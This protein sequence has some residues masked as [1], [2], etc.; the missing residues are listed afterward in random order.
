MGIT[1][2]IAKSFDEYIE[3]AVKLGK[4][5]AWRQQM[6]EMIAVNKHR[7]YHDR[8]CIT[9][10]ENFLESVAKERFEQDCKK[11][12]WRLFA[13]LYLVLGIEQIIRN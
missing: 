13:I 2:T 7:I 9:A 8:T 1:E 3:F 6:S 11:I 5:S 10:L 12:T 4:N